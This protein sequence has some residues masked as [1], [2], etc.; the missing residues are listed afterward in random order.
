MLVPD[1]EVSNKKRLAFAKQFANECWQADTLYGPHA[2]TAKGSPR[3]T[4]LIAFIDDASRLCCHGQFFFEENST[5]FKSAFQQALDKRGLPQMLYVDHGSIYATAELTT[6]AGRLGCR[7]GHT[8]VRDGAAKGKIERFF[9]TLREQFLS[10]QLDLSSLGKLN[11][12]FLAWAEE[13]YNHGPHSTLG[14]KPIERYSLDRARIEFLPPTPYLEELFM[15][16]ETRGVNADNTFSFGAK[17]YEAPADLRHKQIHI[18]FDQTHKRQKTTP[19][20]IPVYDQ[21]QR[22]GEAKRLDRLANDRPPKK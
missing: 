9:R 22:L 8:P 2:R 3:Q 4:K 5:A 18:R 7:L 16:E 10:R 19:E 21:G 20:R 13:Q 11:E 6:I 12:Q 15:A 1:K 14:M 17:R